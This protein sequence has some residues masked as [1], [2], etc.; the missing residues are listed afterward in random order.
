METRFVNGLRR[1]SNFPKKSLGPI[2]AVIIF[3]ITFLGGHF[4]SFGQTPNQWNPT[5]SYPIK[6]GYTSCVTSSAYVYCVG[7]KTSSGTTNAVY[8]ADL[9]TSGINSWQSTT[10]YPTPI[11]AQS[12]VTDFAYIYCV[13]GELGTTE[14]SAVYYTTLSSS[15]IGSW[16]AT[17]SF[18]IAI[19]YSSC[20]ID[21]GYV[22]CLG[23]RLLGGQ[24]NNPI[25]IYYAK[26]SA[27]GG[28]SGGWIS[29]SAYMDY[30]V[31]GESCLANSGYMTCVGGDDYVTMY[32]KFDSTNPGIGTWFNGT[33]YPTRIGD[34]SCVLD[35]NQVY[36]IGGFA[37]GYVANSAFSAIFS[38]SGLGTWYPDVSYPISVVGESCVDNSGYVYCLGG[39]ASNAWT[40]AA[41][42]ISASSLLVSGATSATDYWTVTQP[43]TSQET[44]EYFGSNTTSMSLTINSTTSTDTSSPSTTST[45]TLAN[46]A[47]E[48]PL[49]QSQ[50]QSDPTTSILAV[51][52]IVL[53]IVVAG[54]IYLRRRV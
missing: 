1:K 36:C 42:Y 16:K 34:Q 40:N 21:A 18:P 33:G 27:S 26:L 47:T 12:C 48:S 23:Q 3:L 10:N 31:T 54:F 38:S 50:E 13:G 25:P 17:T 11:E 49:A 35:S 14:T 6:A 29:T 24:G 5:A 46:T 8:F 22:Y 41:Y 32:A 44:T 30:L 51:G 2:L 39:Y 9:S 43:Q 15:G 37:T 4:I 45:F 7:G 52:S 19:D 28:I 20:V 53:A